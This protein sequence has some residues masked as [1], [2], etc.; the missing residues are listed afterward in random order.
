MPMLNPPFPNTD[1][2]YMQHFK[3][4]GE[5]MMS[6]QEYMKMMGMNPFMYMMPVM[7]NMMPN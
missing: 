1:N 6:Q 2:N 3:P 5:N 7:K 4:N